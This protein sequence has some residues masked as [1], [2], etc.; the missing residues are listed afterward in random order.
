LLHFVLFFLNC[1]SCWLLHSLLFWLFN[2]F[3]IC[4]LRL[5]LFVVHVFLRGL[6][7]S[8][9]SHLLNFRLFCS[10]HLGKHCPRFLSSFKVLFIF[11]FYYGCWVYEMFLFCG[12]LF[13]SSIYLSIHLSFWF[14]S[15]FSIAFTMLLLF[16][17]S[18]FFFF[19]CQHLLFCCHLLPSTILVVLCPIKNFSVVVL[20]CSSHFKGYLN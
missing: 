6:W 8:L 12:L 7:S 11:L 10:L 3:A 16:W 4:L 20:S 17:F 5:I 9:F 1:L 18:L 13:H 15:P 2:W 14:F 19:V